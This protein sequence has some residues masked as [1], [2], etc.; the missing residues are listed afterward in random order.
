M[1]GRALRVCS[2]DRREWPEG[3]GHGKVHPHHRAEVAA[4]GKVKGF[5]AK[6]PKRLRYE[7]DEAAS[8]K[9]ENNIM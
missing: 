9:R 4:A 5:C 6:H 1:R 3:R 8:G 2:R 7:V